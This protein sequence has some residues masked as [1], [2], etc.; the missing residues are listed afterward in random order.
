MI[1]YAWVIAMS[2]IGERL[3]EIRESKGIS[4]AELARRIGMSRAAISRYE[5]G[6]RQNIS[7]ETLFMLL[8]ALN[9]DIAEFGFD[10]KQEKAL[11]KY[12][13]QRYSEIHNSA[14][15]SIPEALEIIK[16]HFET[17]NEV[18]I[19]EACERIIE[20]SQLPKYRR[21]YSVD[22]DEQEE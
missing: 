10:K 3:K 5:S 16:S 11:K 13:Q 12:Q 1:K 2:N 9:V 14:N 22:D 19:W 20:M 8:E 7:A 17:M 6:D 4:Q 21:S 18:G 15:A